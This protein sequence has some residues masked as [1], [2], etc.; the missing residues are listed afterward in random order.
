MEKKYILAIDQG[1]SSSRAVVF[2]HQVQIV[3]IEQLEFTQI[4]PKPGWV[5]QDPMEIWESQY[6]V[7]KQVLIKN[8]I[9]ADE[10]AAIGI[11]NQ[12]ETTIVWERK[13]GK[14]VTN[15][16]VWQ[17]K[18]TSDFCANLKDEGLSARIKSKTGLVIDSY[19][20]ATKLN[21]IL[22]QI[23]GLKQRA[24]NGEICFGTVDTWL[25]WKLTN[26][27]F[28]L[29]DYSNASRTMLFNINTLEWDKELLDIFD[30]PGALLPEVKNSSE[31]YGYTHPK[32]F[33]GTEIPISGIAGDQQ[34]ALFGQACFEEGSAKNTYG[35]GCFML[36]NT[37]EKPV[38][39]GSGM[40]TTIAWKIG[41]KTHYAL[42]GSVFYSRR[43][44]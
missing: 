22:N 31:I 16:I 37:G 5:E 17:D 38:F 30:I 24:Q 1:T 39:S 35:T 11:S 9:R 7:C 6:K 8:N 26:G 14:P 21:W 12:R 34:S 15:A 18:R 32:L 41:G 27:Q 3:G 33:D 4:Y 23:P 28:H 10:I 2:D 36:L 44:H 25:V 42:E 19:F 13:T 40:L 20:S 29:T 43:S